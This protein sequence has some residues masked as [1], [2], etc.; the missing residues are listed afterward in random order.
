MST[1]EW[2]PNK[3]NLKVG[4][5]VRLDAGRGN[6]SKVIIKALTPKAMFATVYSPLSQLDTWEVM[7]NRLTP[8]EPKTT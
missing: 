5:M 2:T 7:T 8:L 4:D 3:F 6:S 1:E